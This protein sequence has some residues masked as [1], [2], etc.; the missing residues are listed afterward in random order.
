LDLPE[1]FP[2]YEY[3]EFAESNGDLWFVVCIS[4]FLGVFLVELGGQF[5][6][7]VDLKGKCFGYG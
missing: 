7:R 3:F 6:V 2:A 4:K 1:W 5:F